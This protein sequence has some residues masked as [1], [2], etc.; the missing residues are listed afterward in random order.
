MRT[1]VALKIGYATCTSDR[2][3]RTR[4]CVSACA[5][6]RQVG[7]SGRGLLLLLR[8]GIKNRL[9][10]SNLRCQGLEFFDIGCRKRRDRL[11]TLHEWSS[12]LRLREGSIILRIGITW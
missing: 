9:R 2:F 6:A 10:T 4:F 7:C 3:L 12:S 11:W 5:Q 8:I 1:C